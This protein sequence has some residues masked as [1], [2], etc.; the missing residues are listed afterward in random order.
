MD[1]SLLG[2]APMRA[3]SPSTK[4]CANLKTGAMRILLKGT[5]KAKVVKKIVIYTTAPVAPTLPSI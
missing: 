4:A 2:A 3:A 5:C 1:V